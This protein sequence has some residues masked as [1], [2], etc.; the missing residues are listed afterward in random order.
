MKRIS[1]VCAVLG[2]FGM[3][4]QASPANA[5][6][7]VGVGATC[8]A[9]YT[10]YCVTTEVA[11]AGAGSTVTGGQFAGVCKAQTTGAS[12]TSVTCS[13]SGRNRTVS[14]PGPVG[15]SAV[16]APTTSLTGH[17][18]CWS[19]TGFFTDPLGGVVDVTDTGCAIVTI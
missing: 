11:G 1:L 8:D 14:L 9:I 15:A 12:L 4:A 5:A 2:V 6:A 18:V 13:A 17:T 16:T 10:Q 19:S 3:V 7:G